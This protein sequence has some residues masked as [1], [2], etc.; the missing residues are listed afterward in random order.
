MTQSR[1]EIHNVQGITVGDNRQPQAH[2]QIRFETYNM[3]DLIVG[4]KA[5]RGRMAQSMFESHSMHGMVIG[6]YSQPRALDPE[7]V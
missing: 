3:Q 7:H 2:A 4:D 6:F 1:S 5:I